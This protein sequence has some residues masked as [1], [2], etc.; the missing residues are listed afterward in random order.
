MEHDTMHLRIAGWLIELRVSPTTLAAEV[1]A[2][3]AAFTVKT[4]EAPD[5]FVEV[6]NDAATENHEVA[7]GSILQARLTQLGEDYLLDSAQVYGMIACAR[8]RAMLRICSDLPSREAEYFLRIALAL[9]AL[10]RGGLL[11]HCAALKRSDQVYLF[12]GQSGSGKSTVVRLSRLA[13]RAM[14][15]GDDLILIRWER[16]SWQAYGT[17]FWNLETIGRDGQQESG[18]VAHI[19]KLIQDRSV[20]VEPMG[21]AAA[22]AELI[23]NCPVVNDQ[24]ALLPGLID[25]CRSVAVAIPVE[26]LHFRKD[27]SFWDVIV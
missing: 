27:D 11:V 5:F 21:G 1:A 18:R 9:F 14:A 2:R 19:Y 22:T 7:S 16:G 24:L 6:H 26:R 23:A 10:P 3:Y 15:L 20:F 12:V 13:H 4:D 17:P 8:G 25:R